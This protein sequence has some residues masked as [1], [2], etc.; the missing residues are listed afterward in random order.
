LLIDHFRLPIENRPKWAVSVSGRCFSAVVR[1]CGN[2]SE[3]NWSLSQSESSFKQFHFGKDDGL[4]VPPPPPRLKP[5]LGAGFAKLVC[6]I[7]SPKELEVKILIAKEL[8]ALQ[9]LLPAPLPP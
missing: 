5:A 2:R 7:L 3:K 8:G 4:E 6:K 9:R 1:G